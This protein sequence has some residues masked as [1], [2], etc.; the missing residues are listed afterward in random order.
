MDL[1]VSQQNVEHVVDEA[2]ADLELEGR[3]VIAK[4][5]VTLKTVGSL[6]D[7]VV[8]HSV[9]VA[10][11]VPVQ[12]LVGNPR[13][14]AMLASVVQC[15][16]GRDHYFVVWQG[17][18]KYLQWSHCYFSLALAEHE[19]DYLVGSN[20][21]SKAVCKGLEDTKHRISEQVD[22]GVQ[23]SRADVFSNNLD[24][25]ELVVEVNLGPLD[26][27]EGH[28]PAVDVLLVHLEVK[29]ETG[30][31]ALEDIDLEVVLLIEIEKPSLEAVSTHA[32]THVVH[33]HYQAVVLDPDLDILLVK[34]H[35]LKPNSANGLLEGEVQVKVVE[36]DL[37]QHLVQ[38]VYKNLLAP[39]N[40]L[41][42]GTHGKAS[43]DTGHS[44]Q[45]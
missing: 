2:V 19:T 24:F 36:L 13:L 20:W 15:Y 21:E 30:H 11:E 3:S 18:Q 16:L 39:L 22:S 32:A 28:L 10:L 6:S 7:L 5:H 14:V 35:G 8:A 42:R 41:L 4:L 12:S 34:L 40:H 17:H 45:K 1:V 29:S 44:A 26:A 9:Y 33:L 27:E 31:A 25:P 43:L 37:A 23:K 38:V